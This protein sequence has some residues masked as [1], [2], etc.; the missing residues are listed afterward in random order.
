MLWLLHAFL[1]RNLHCHFLLSPVRVI[2][3]FICISIKI[4]FQIYC[5]AVS[6][7]PDFF[8]MLVSTKPKGWQK[9]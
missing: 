8:M 1:L 7:F 9:F 4:F 5:L 3:L 2:D 6:I